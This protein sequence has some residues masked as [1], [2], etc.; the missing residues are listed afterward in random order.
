MPDILV[1]CIPPGLTVLLTSLTSKHGLP[2][3]KEITEG[4][5]ST[6]T[7]AGTG[8]L[9]PGQ[10]PGGQFCRVP[11]CLTLLLAA[12]FH[13]SAVPNGLAVTI[14]MPKIFLNI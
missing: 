14:F 11:P 10:P 8:K 12:G 2:D 5:K 4:T 6:Q 7:H 3:R 1:Q 9:Q 13:I